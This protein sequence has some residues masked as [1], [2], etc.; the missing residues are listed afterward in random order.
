VVHHFRYHLL[1]PD[2][3]SYRIKELQRAYA[4]RVLLVQAGA[5]FIFNMTAE[6]HPAGRADPGAGKAVCH[7]CLAPRQVDVEDVVKPLGDI[8]KAAVMNDCTLVCAWS[9]EVRK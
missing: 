4:L 7:V 5:C 3:I 6:Q 1:H 2:Y 9:A 8:T